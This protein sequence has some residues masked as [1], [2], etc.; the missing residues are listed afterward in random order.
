MAQQT[1]NPTGDGTFTGTWSGSAGLRWQ[2]V[3]DHPDSTGA[4]KLTHG[5]TA[6]AGNFSFVVFSV[7]AG[8]TI[9]NVQVVYYDQK[10]ASQGAS[11]GAFL[12]IDGV[13]YA[14]NDAHNPSNGSWVL[15]L[16]M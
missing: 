6:G 14:T 15:R 9:T 11:W 7:P 5:T 10:T 12:R 1:R 3:D 8:S 2:S 13:D 16:T 4:D